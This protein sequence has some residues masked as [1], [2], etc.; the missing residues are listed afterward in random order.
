MTKRKTK[1]EQENIEKQT[2]RK[3][4]LIANVKY[5]GKRYKIGEEIEIDAKDYDSF[6]KAGLVKV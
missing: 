3:A 1:Q 5:K 4:K 6:V 2:V